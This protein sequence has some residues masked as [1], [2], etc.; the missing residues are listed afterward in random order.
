MQKVISKDGTTIAYDQT[1]HGPAIIMVGG[2]LSWRNFPPAIQLAGLLAFHF[3]V[4]NYDRRGRGDSSD[5]QPYAVEREIEDIAALIDAVGGS[6]Y[7]YGIS[8][9]AA[10]AMYAAAVGLNIKKLALYE[11]PFV[12][13]D[14]SAHQPPANYQ[15]Q[16]KALIAA[17]RRGD[18]IKFFINKIMGA[19]IFIVWI[20][21]LMPMW[22]QLKAVAHTLPYDMSIVGNCEL[23]QAVSSISIPTLVIGGEKSPIGLRH[24]VRAVAGAIPNARQRELKGQNHNVSM[25]VLAPVLDEFFRESHSTTIPSGVF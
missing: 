21:R 3:T 10:L 22:K 5:T 16:L 25:P 23:P 20:V 7:V 11:P 8:S 12:A 19:P 1:G 24:A 4:I 14:K 13:V 2:A 17:D 9:G 6:A 15:G 18:A